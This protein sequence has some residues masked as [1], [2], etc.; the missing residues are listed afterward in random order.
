MK[1]FDQQA[2]AISEDQWQLNRKKAQ[3]RQRIGNILIG[4]PL[5]IVIASSLY[6]VWLGWHH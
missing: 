2:R 4:L 6:A 1:T 5:A 3:R